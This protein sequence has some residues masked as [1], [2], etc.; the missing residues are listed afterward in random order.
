[1][2]K[3]CTMVMV[4]MF[5]LSTM[6]YA[7]ISSSGSKSSSS[8]TSTRTSSP[9]SYSSNTPSSSS[10]L[11]TSKPS[12]PATTPTQPVYQSGGGL[13]TT[14]TQT[15]QADLQRTQQLQ[16]EQAR[17]NIQRDSYQSQPNAG[18]G[19]FGTGLFAGM[20]AGSL[21]HPTTV[22]TPMGAGAGYVQAPTSFSII[23]FIIDI[24][25]FSLFCYVVY[26]LWRFYKK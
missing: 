5:A 23:F 1:M 7:G 21:I 8:S 3:L 22:V 26:R 19:G 20:V 25:L 17:T 6:C 15:Q 24:L 10:G 13:S 12:A 18:F 4:I 14:K 16:R 9:S 2:K 11:S